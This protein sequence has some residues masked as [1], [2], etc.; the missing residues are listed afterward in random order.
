M[1]GCPVEQGCE[2]Y[3]IAIKDIRWYEIDYTRP[4]IVF[5]R[6]CIIEKKPGQD[7][8]SEKFPR[9]LALISRVIRAEVF[10]VTV[11]IV[12]ACVANVQWILIPYYIYIYIPCLPWYWLDKWYMYIVGDHFGRERIIWI[13]PSVRSSTPSLPDA[14][15][16]VVEFAFLPRS[17]Q[18]AQ[19]SD[20]RTDAGEKGEADVD[21]EGERHN[22]FLLK[23]PLWYFYFHISHAKSTT[24]L[25][26][27]PENVGSWVNQVI[28]WLGLLRPWNQQTMANF[29]YAVAEKFSEALRRLA[30]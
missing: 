20:G 3:R 27:K 25:N 12:S 29:G 11:Y 7:G 19:R 8:P 17:V 4:G 9:L 15:L 6:W 23:G 13:S 21:G 2:G 14:P 24:W 5:V 10:I 30:R 28:I 16:V 26:D 22:V 18:K 1:T